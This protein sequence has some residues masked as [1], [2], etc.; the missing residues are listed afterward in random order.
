[1]KGTI[2]L[3]VRGAV[4][5]NRKY[6]DLCMGTVGYCDEE[7]GNTAVCIHER[8]AWKY[9]CMELS[10]HFNTRHALCVAKR[11]GPLSH[12]IS[13]IFVLG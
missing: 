13:Q 12:Y 7:V 2:S 1:M 5:N 10:R 4:E 11:L 3:D 9:L 8:Y 6:D